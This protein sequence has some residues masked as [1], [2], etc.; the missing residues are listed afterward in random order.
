MNPSLDN[1]AKPMYNIVTAIKELASSGARIA[2]NSDLDYGVKIKH[3]EQLIANGRTS[4]LGDVKKMVHE[5][6]RIEIAEDVFPSKLM[7]SVLQELVLLQAGNHGL[8]KDE[9]V[10]EATSANYVSEPTRSDENMDSEVIQDLQ[11]E[12]GTSRKLEN[13]EEYFVYIAQTDEQATQTDLKMDELVD[14]ARIERSVQKTEKLVK[15]MMMQN[16]ARTAENSD[17]FSELVKYLAAVRDW[18]TYKVSYLGQIV[19]KIASIVKRNDKPSAI[20]RKTDEAIDALLSKKFERAVKQPEKEI[21]EVELARAF[22]LWAKEQVGCTSIESA[23][24][25][26]PTRMYKLCNFKGCLYAEIDTSRNIN[27]HIREQHP[28]FDGD[29]NTVRYLRRAM[30]M[31][32]VDIRKVRYEAAMLSEKE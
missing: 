17:I 29:R 16:S 23:N 2:M 7:L 13:Q 27:R 15:D 31:A 11:D 32:E 18:F 30:T 19:R 20:L 24:E 26:K 12:S 4:Q 10:N 6:V 8:R 21:E 5:P 25:V 14:L 22:I 3:L 1:F 28:E 9:P